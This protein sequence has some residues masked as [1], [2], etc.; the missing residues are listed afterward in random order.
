M[1]LAP[2]YVIARNRGGRPTL[3]HKLLSGTSI[4]TACGADMSEWSRAF[5]TDPIHA[6]LCRRC[7]LL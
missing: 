5:Q 7:N 4:L 2:G 1:T 3:Q 6:L